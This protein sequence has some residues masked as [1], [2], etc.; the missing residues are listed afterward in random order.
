MEQQSSS[1]FNAEINEDEIDLKE[2]LF[3]YLRHW[4]M[5]AV[6]AAVGLAL[7]VFFNKLVTPIYSVESSVLIKD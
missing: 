1:P 2:I 7:A 4:K 5:I 6:C 3:K